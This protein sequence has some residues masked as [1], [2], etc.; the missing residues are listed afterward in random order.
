M[1]C[2]QADICTAQDISFKRILIPCF[3]PFCCLFCGFGRTLSATQL[4]NKIEGAWTLLNIHREEIGLYFYF[5]VFE[6]QFVLIIMCLNLYIDLY[7]I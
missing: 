5:L 6:D 7:L 3:L 2:E 1:G 4:R